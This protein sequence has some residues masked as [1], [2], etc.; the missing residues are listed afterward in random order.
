MAGLSS[1]QINQSFQGLLNI[2]TS[3]LS[4]TYREILDGNGNSTGVFISTSGLSGSIQALTALS[5]SYAD[6]SI[7][8]LNAT[9]ATSSLSSS[10]SLSSLNSLNS[11]L[12]LVH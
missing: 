5:A 1:L 3:S 4:S 8:S 9:F 2:F 7:N 6:N 11:F 12:Q 10:Y